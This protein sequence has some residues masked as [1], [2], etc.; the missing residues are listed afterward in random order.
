MDT[1]EPRVNGLRNISFP[2]QRVSL[3]LC[4]VT[5]RCNTHWMGTSLGWCQGFFFF[6]FVLAVQIFG[7]LVGWAE[8]G[9]AALQPGPAVGLGIVLIIGCL[10]GTEHPNVYAH[11]PRLFQFRIT[12]PGRA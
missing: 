5:A 10:L 11:P 7:E 6:C 4:F 1:E 9:I 3:R 12:D 2:T 8:V